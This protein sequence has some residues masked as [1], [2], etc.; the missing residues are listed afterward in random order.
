MGEKD[1]IDLKLQNIAKQKSRRDLERYRTLV[2]YLEFQFSY[3]MQGNAAQYN[4]V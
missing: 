2:R 1:M 4:A 3:L